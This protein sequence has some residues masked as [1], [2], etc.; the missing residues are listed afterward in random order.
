MHESRAF[1]G[2]LVPFANQEAG[3][4]S[5]TSACTCTSSRRK[6]RHGRFS[7]LNEY[8]LP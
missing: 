3:V 7:Q 5:G 2:V 8:S 4:T 1:V 6:P